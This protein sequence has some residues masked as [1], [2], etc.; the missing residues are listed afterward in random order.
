MQICVTQIAEI[1]FER[2]Y[3]SLDITVVNDD[4]YWCIMT[5]G[6]QNAIELEI[7]QFLADKS[8]D[9]K[10]LNFNL[11]TI[12]PFCALVGRFFFWEHYKL[13]KKKLYWAILN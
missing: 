7:L 13:L 2:F 8:I 10:M 12:V 9:M 5:T 11:Y 6:S 1:F 4:R 3:I